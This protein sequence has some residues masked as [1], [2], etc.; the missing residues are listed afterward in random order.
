M[1]TQ[2]IHITLAYL[3]RLRDNLLRK[4]HYRDFFGGKTS[5]AEIPNNRRQLIR[6]KEILTKHRSVC[7]H[8]IG[9]FK[10]HG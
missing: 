8:S 1:S 2:F 9:T 5:I 10:R 6:T 7:K 4:R 3:T